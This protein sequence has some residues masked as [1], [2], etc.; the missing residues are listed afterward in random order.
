MGAVS[1]VTSVKQELK[2]FQ[3]FMKPDNKFWEFMHIQFNG[4]LEKL[5]IKDHSKKKILKTT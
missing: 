1:P 4:K 5:N 2:S 3:K